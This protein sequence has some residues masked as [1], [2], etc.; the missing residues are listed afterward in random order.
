[1]SL[2]STVMGLFMVLL[3]IALSIAPWVMKGMAFVGVM[4]FEI[5]VVLTFFGIIICLVGWALLFADLTG[6]E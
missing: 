6:G 5:K 1:M 3:G 2:I 4:T